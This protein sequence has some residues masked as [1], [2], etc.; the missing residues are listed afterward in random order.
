MKEFRNNCKVWRWNYWRINVWCW[1]L[2]LCISAWQLTYLMH[3]FSFYN[4]IYYTPLHVSSTMCS[5][6]GGQNCIILYL[7][8][9]PLWVAVRCTG[10][11]RTGW[12]AH[13]IPTSPLLTSQRGFTNCQRSAE[14]NIKLFSIELCLCCL[15]CHYCCERCRLLN[16][17]GLIMVFTVW[18]RRV[19]KIAKSEY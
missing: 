13:G 5:S 4:K 15:S 19:S 17:S 18:F 3:K 8:S 2:I 16:D 7:V 6:S 1:R 11:E 10:W 12:N 14:V 9:S